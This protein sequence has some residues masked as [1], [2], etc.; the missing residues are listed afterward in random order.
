MFVGRR[1]E[2]AALEEAQDLAP[3]SVLV[4][5][6]WALYWRRQGESQVALTV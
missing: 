4:R 1:H 2:L 3:D 5:S 6:L